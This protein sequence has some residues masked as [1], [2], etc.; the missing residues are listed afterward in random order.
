MYMKIEEL[1]LT[2]LLRL[3]SSLSDVLPK[4]ITIIDILY[5][6][7]LTTNKNI[8]TFYYD[9]LDIAPTEFDNFN[10]V[11]IAPISSIVLY[12]Q[13]PYSSHILRTS[14]YYQARAGPV[15]SAKES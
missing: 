11:R 9:F 7:A 10:S 2:A 14:L 15:A 1:T 4:V 5:F 6:E 13:L 12:I 8:V 3:N